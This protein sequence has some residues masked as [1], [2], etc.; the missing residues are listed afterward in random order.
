[1]K[2]IKFIKCP[3]LYNKDNFSYKEDQ[4]VF[5]YILS[6]HLAYSITGEREVVDINNGNIK[7]LFDCIYE[8]IPFSIKLLESAIICSPKDR[9]DI[10]EYLVKL[11]NTLSNLKLVKNAL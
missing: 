4:D 8:E 2:N 10:E 5:I 3:K 6:K 11:K 9:K 7:F 1:M